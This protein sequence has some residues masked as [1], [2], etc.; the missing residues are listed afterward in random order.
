[1]RRQTMR[2]VPLSQIMSTAVV[3]VAPH[4]TMA[5][6]LDIL[7]ERC[8]SCLVVEEDARPVGIVTERD[9]VKCYD[10][11]EAGT[12]LTVAQ[13]MTS[14]PLSVPADLDHFEAFKLMKE[15][16]FR[17][18]VVTDAD[19]RVAGVV[20]ETDF[21]RHLG[22]DF[23][24]RPKDV[25]AVM[26]PVATADENASLHGVLSLLAQP[27]IYCVA[28]ESQGRAVGILTER[29]AVR[30]LRQHS[31]VDGLRAGEVMGKPLHTIAP[32]ASLLDATE[33]LRVHAIRHLVV[34]D[35]DGVASGVIS[36]HEIVQGLESEYVVHLER[37]IAEKNEAL[38]AL[39]QAHEMLAE[40][41]QALSGTVAELE[42]THEE[43]REF[44]RVA[45]HDLAE[46]SRLV[47]SFCQLLLRRHGS[48]L[49]AEGR[50]LAHFAIDGARRMRRL[51]QDL[52]VYAAPSTE[53][54]GKLE[55]VSLLVVV[56][57]VL[58]LLAEEVKDAHAVVDVGALPSVALARM[59]LHE[60]FRHLIANALIYRRDGVSP[61]IRIGAEDMGDCWRLW[62]E[63]N[64]IGID[65]VYRDDVF[66]L[67]TRLHPPGPRSGT[68]A[69][70]AIVKRI[71][72][73]AGGRIWIEGD[74]A[75]GSTFVFT[76]PK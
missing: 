7:S 67:F 23:Y 41:S 57:A 54:G 47:V 34:V 44:A 60:L 30:L 64:G 69:G 1:M 32:S 20:T 24:V 31:P 49:G 2:A 21:V 38:A 28:I 76:L 37:I 14:T 72:S 6:A 70:L 5:E 26:A 59:S 39:G 51:V 71:V 9:V 25:R 75:Q 8:I 4:T 18:L 63:D 33:A 27:G 58:D 3:T 10:G 45:S 56:S 15:H 19:G 13:V 35:D 42:A 12:Q 36:E 73:D 65:P 55:P 29:D 61:H 17:H 50:E 43:L 16:R 22:V 62:V 11:V 48:D 53:P 40:Q 74:P 52:A 68:G 46:P 66:R